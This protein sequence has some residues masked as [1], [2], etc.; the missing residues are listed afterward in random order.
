MASQRIAVIGGGAKAA[1]VCAKAACLRELFNLP[2]EVTVFE[3][4]RL[5]AAWSGGHG[6]TDGRQQLCTP[7][8][9]DAGYPYALD[10]FGAP[11]AQA[12]LSR[13]SWPAF[14][15]ASNLMADWVDRGRPRPTH[16]EFSAYIS[17]CVEGS[18]AQVAYG[19][20]DRL[21]V[22][23][24]RWDVG[25][26]DRDSGRATLAPGFD[27]VLVTSAGPASTRL[28]KVA[29]PRV[30]D[31]F[32]FWRALDG[33][34]AMAAG[35]TE[36]IVV[37]GSGGT[38]AAVAGWLARQHADAQIVILGD[39][40]ALYARSVTVFENRAFRVADIWRSLSS[41]DRRA[42]TDRLT[43]G[44]VWSNVLEA[45]SQ[46]PHVEYRPG[47]A[48]AVRHE[49]PG[50]PTGELMVDFSTSADRAKVRGQP[51]CLVVDATGFD[52]TWFA[53]LLPDAMRDEVLSDGERMRSDMSSSLA[54][55]LTGGPPLHV[56]GLSQ[57]VSPAF[58]S[59]MALGDL[60]DAILRP[61]VKDALA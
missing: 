2:L 43:R 36:P 50:D 40:A 21:L 56:P 57:A 28:S 46:A 16:S 17:F 26:T 58:T 18:G 45:L 27:G 55:P 41:D 48:L 34:A 22:N 33:V 35:A 15:V 30:F 11:V 4:T 37:I 13:F 9:R 20:V 23:A 31:G 6:Y 14:A 29:D 49:P 10:T 39:Q 25:Y 44:A 1:A 7:A 38:A 47:R 24:S 5:G 54:L 61:Y 12:M 52:A 19:A 8:E 51:A 60:S 42:F 3:Q 32:T 53:G 59:L